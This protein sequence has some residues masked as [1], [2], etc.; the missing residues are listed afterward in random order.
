MIKL[1]Q[2]KKLDISVR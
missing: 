2:I 1:Y